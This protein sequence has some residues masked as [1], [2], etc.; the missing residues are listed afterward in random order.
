MPRVA[1]K[2]GAL[3]NDPSKPRINLTTAIFGT[4]PIQAHYGH[5][6]VIGMLGNDEWG[7]CVYSGAG[8]ITEILS[9]YGQGTES[10]VT[11]T[12]ALT[13]YAAE[14]GFNE[15]AGPPGDNPTDQG[16]T[17]QAGLGYLRTTGLAG[18]KIAAFGE[19]L[20]GNTNEWQQA[21]AELGP[22]MAGVSV[23][24]LEEEQFN[25]G[26]MWTGSAAGEENHCIILTGYQP[27][28]VWCQTWGAIQGMT[29]EWF[30]ENVHELWAVVS[31]EWVSMKTG[32][33]PGHV[34]LQ[35]VGQQF[36]AL[37]GQPSPF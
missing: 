11:T 17:L 33:D 35:V 7:C 8:H 20:V 23:G 31:R 13:A 26:Q 21:L 9:F 19:L 10:E 3:P 5:E 14:T 6:P 27:G 30:S 32:T 12:Q 34:D 16:S 28:V 18:V 15:S 36:T 29:M 2:R 37:T 4:A 24:G 22:L 1:G 25:A